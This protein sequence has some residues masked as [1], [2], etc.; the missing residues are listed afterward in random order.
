MDISKK[1]LEKDSIKIKLSMLWLFVMLNYIYA[2]ILTL[3]DSAALN[4]ILSGAIGVTPLYMLLG[5]IMME[6]PIM[7][8][9]LSL[10]LER[11]VNR[12][13]NIAAG[14]IKTLAVSG[15]LFVGK[16]SFYY[17]FFAI[18]EITA[19]VTIIIMAWRWKVQENK[20]V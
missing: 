8:V 4:D 6:I 12:S 13:A 11:K 19:T 14:I 18:I 2:D 7:M 10:I 20:S 5:A 1:I 15:S 3:M 9:F 16:L 17:L